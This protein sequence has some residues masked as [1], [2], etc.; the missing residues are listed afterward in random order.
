MLIAGHLINEAILSN[1]TCWTRTRVR[2]TWT[3]LESWKIQCFSIIFD[4][5]S[6]FF[7]QFI[8]LF[9]SSPGGFVWGK[10]N[11]FG[12]WANKNMHRKIL[13]ITKFSMFFVS[14]RRLTDLAATFFSV[15][16]Y[17]DK[18]FEGWS[19]FSREKTTS[20]QHGVDSYAAHHA[21]A[22]HTGGSGGGMGPHTGHGHPH[23][24]HPH[25][26]HPH[27][28]LAAASPFYAQ[29]VAMMSSW[30]AYDGAGFQR[31]SPYGE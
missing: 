7:G 20:W 29:N 27:T 16:N 11:V 2:L 5:R 23:S 9:T 1:Y 28:T 12:V 15:W 3:R 25:T 8:Y 13:R 30:R 18:G 10:E 14:L 6:I 21:L 24:G 19:I 22:S 17:G 31:A 4:F 26:G